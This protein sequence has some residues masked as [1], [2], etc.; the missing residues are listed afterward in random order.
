MFTIKFMIDYIINFLSSTILSLFNGILSYMI[1]EKDE[2]VVFR[3]PKY[4]KTGNIIYSSFFFSASDYITT[5]FSLSH[6]LHVRYFQIEKIIIQWFCLLIVIRR[7][8]FCTFQLHILLYVN[9][10]I[11]FIRYTEIVIFVNYQRKF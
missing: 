8:I 4:H 6:F 11:N 2:Y 5:F 9:T 7:S 3:V 10:F 1:N